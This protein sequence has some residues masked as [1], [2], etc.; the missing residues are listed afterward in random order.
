MSYNPSS[1]SRKRG[2]KRRQSVT[3]RRQKLDLKKSAT[4][5]EV[6]HNNEPLILIPF[7]VVP[8]KTCV[9]AYYQ[10]KF[11]RGHLVI[12]PFDIFISH[13]QHGCTLTI[14]VI[15]MQITSLTSHYFIS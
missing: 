12:V 15:A 2:Q 11:P 3:Q 5:T 14:T 1:A 4:V 13:E 7:K 10:N 8:I 9:C 6:W